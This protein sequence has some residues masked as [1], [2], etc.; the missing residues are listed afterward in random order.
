MQD[1][2]SQIAQVEYQGQAQNTRSLEHK[3]LI[4]T[5]YC[6]QHRLGLKYFDFPQF[7]IIAHHAAH[8]PQKR[9]N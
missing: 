6:I 4:N 2:R 5:S 8:Q 9:E 3:P 7:L 1:C